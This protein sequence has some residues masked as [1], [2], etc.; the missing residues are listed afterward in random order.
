V[1]EALRQRSDFL[2][3]QGLGE[4]P[5]ARS[6]SAAILVAIN[7]DVIATPGEFWRCLVQGFPCQ[8]DCALEPQFQTV[9]Y[10][11]RWLKARYNR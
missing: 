7:N 3:E 9:L 11:E 5:A 10:I 2:I 1:R 6:A 8:A 4:R